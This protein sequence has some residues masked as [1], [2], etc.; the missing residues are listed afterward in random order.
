MA[1]ENKKSVFTN[2]FGL[3]RYFNKVRPRLASAKPVWRGP[4]QYF[5]DVLEKIQLKRNEAS[6]KN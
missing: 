3:D 1:V 6:M 5:E 2:A 4:P